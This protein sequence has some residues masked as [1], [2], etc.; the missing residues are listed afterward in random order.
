MI[1]I[2]AAIALVVAALSVGGC[3]DIDDYLPQ[4]IDQ[5]EPKK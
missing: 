2:L 3:A 5:G 1:R 4:P